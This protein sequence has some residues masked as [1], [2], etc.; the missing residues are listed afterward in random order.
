MSVLG[1]EPGTVLFVTTATSILVIDGLAC[2]Q[3]ANHHSSMGDDWPAEPS[4]E[5]HPVHDVIRHPT[6]QLR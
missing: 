6:W 2:D 1:I 4:V 3:L 5:P